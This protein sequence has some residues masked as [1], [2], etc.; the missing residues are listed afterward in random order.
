[1]LWGAAFYLVALGVVAIAKPARGADFLGAF[2]QTRRANWI[3]AIVRF[4][5]GLA[6][7]VAAPALPGTTIARIAGL[8]LMG[9]AM[10]M[11]VLPDLHRR[12]AASSVA[13][14]VPHMRWLGL[15]SIAGGIALS[16]L[17][18]AAR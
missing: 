14:V 1:M 18:L 6:L 9:T 3:E 11:P 5:C 10:L 4:A 17:L 8:F 2:A 7:M 12:L 13:R 16:A 15:G